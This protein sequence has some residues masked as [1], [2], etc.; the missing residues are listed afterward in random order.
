MFYLHTSNRTEN[1][2]RHLVEV[3]RQDVRRDAFAPE[4]FLVQGQGMERMIA[5]WL[6]DAFGVWCHFRTLHPLGLFDEIAGQL[7]LAIEAQAF[8]RRPLVWRIESL[9]RDA[10][11]PDLAPLLPYCGGEN[12]GL[13]R[14]QLAW[15][16][17]YVFDQY[18]ILRPDLL[19][20]WEQGRAIARHPT[21]PWQMALWR[22]LAAQ[23]GEGCHRGSMLQRLIALLEDDQPVP[24]LPSRLSVFGLHS[25]PPLFLAVLRALARRTDVHLYLLSPSGEY[26]G[27]LPG[28]R[29]WARRVARVPADDDGSGTADGHP[30]LVALGRQGSDFQAM[31]LDQVDFTMKFQSFADPLGPGDASVLHRL[32]S[33]ILRNRV[34]AA[35]REPLSAV[36]ES[37]IVVSCHSRLREMEVLRDHLLDRLHRDPGLE[38]RHIVVMAPDIQQYAAL[39]PAVFADIQHS[40]AD[41][42]LRRRNRAVAAFM[43]FLDLC[44]SRFGWAEVL[45]LLEQEVIASRFDLSGSD[46]A[47]IR[48]WAV[49]AGIRWG[50]SAEQRRELG[51]PAFGQG[52]WQAG[53]ERLL[54]G[55]VTGGDEMVDGILPYADIEGAPARALGGLC[56]FLAILGEAERELSVGRS[57]QHW[58]EL[59]GGYAARLLA[60]DD[61]QEVPELQRLLAE[62]DAGSGHT[63]EVDLAVVRAW[64][65]NA[66]AESLS[67][68]GF[69][70]GRLTFCSMLPMRS[71][72]FRVICLLGLNDGQFPGLDRHATFD[73]LGAATRLGDRSRR[74]DDRYQFLEALLAARDTFYLSYVGRSMKSNEELPPSVVVAELLEVVHRQ[75]GLAPDRLLCRHPLQPFSRRYFD[76]S[77][78]RLFSYDAEACAAA[79]RFATPRPAEPWWEGGTPGVG[80]TVTVAG[81]LSF[82]RHP[83]RWFVRS[84]L[85]IELDLAADQPEDDEPFAAEGL[86]AY[87]VD[88]ELVEAHLAGRGAALLPRLQE[89]G[90]WPLGMAGKVL[91][92]KRIEEVDSLVVRIRAAGMGEP[93]PELPV[94][95][96][97]GGLRLAGTLGHRHERGF[98]LYRN[99]SCR[100][101]DLLALWLHGLLAAQVSGE[102]V[103]VAGIFRDRAC[104][105][106]VDPASRPDLADFAAVFIAGSRR[107]SPLHVE[108]AWAYVQQLEKG[109]EAALAG[110]RKAMAQVLEREY[111]VESS[112]LLRGRTVEELIGP[113]FAAMARTLVD[114][115]WRALR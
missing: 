106:T 68:S 28:R 55:Y 21:E 87:E 107:P 95:V 41:C 32:Q 54:M 86:L 84:G 93:L 59:L 15:Q 83:Q 79:R 34:D 101:R 58:A 26:W 72:P 71:I 43:D 14:F 104:R 57:L 48:Y 56:E 61:G 60:E 23:A 1:L 8:A 75:Y 70:R 90:R 18:Q 19:A 77:D 35:E 88:R 3:L 29:E 2:L 78:P 39:I 9:L 67:A 50:L 30:L 38:L 111:E 51:L 66:C 99:G 81:F 49:A 73:L 115:V 27:D 31:L 36:D 40:I 96:A 76:G 45:D 92:E 65:E 20:A 97:A 33:D 102:E 11:D 62:L 69:L 44:D 103:N 82:F 7:G 80:E 64:L 6:A 89:Q 100:G 52:S 53:L 63:G 16:L 110:A 47:R 91:F 42:S 105:G 109:D 10:G 12:G 94:D 37:L 98:L 113:E 85:G 108:P 24:P 13:K 112:L 74:E 22:R 4:Y 17:A 114:P 25:M 5:Q 46:L